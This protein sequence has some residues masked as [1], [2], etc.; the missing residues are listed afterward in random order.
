MV[1]SICLLFQQCLEGTDLRPH[2]LTTL[3]PPLQSQ[4]LDHL[5]GHSL[6]LEP[7][8]PEVSPLLPTNQELQDSPGLFHWDGGHFNGL[9]SLH[10]LASC[11]HFFLDFYSDHKD[12]A[13]EGRRSF[14]R[15]LTRRSTRVP[16]ASWRGKISTMTTPPSGPAKAVSRWKV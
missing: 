10:L 7:T 8:N 12:V 4:V 3:Q 13:L 5:L 6:P 1:P 9:V 14:F 2:T 11:T 16:H 15:V